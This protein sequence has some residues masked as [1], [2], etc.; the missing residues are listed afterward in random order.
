MDL[1]QRLIKIYRKNQDGFTVVLKNNRITQYDPNKHG[2]YVVSYKTMIEID[3]FM[4]LIN[5]RSNDFED[6][7]YGGWYNKEDGVF[8]IERNKSFESVIDAMTF[9]HLYNQ[10]YIW[11]GELKYTIPTQ[12]QSKVEKNDY[13]TFINRKLD[14]INQC[15]LCYGNMNKQFPYKR[16]MDKGTVK[17][18]KRLDKFAGGYYDYKTGDIII[19][20]YGL[21][22]FAKKE[23]IDLIKAVCS[24]ISHETIHRVLHKEQG[25]ET[26]YLFDCIA[27]IM[28][29]YKDS[30]TA[31]MPLKRVK[32]K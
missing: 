23:G 19:Q 11:D 22:F 10:K 31:G 6:G 4:G 8:Y 21:T 13:Y 27:G 24:T 7:I 30:L 14:I 20:G 28:L 2:R 9:A 12:I 26:C 3:E 25:F 16:E 17:I 18:A 29:W 1:D 32:I 5:Y 15:R